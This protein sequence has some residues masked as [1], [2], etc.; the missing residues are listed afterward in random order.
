MLLLVVM[1][2]TSRLDIGTHRL[3]LTWGAW[4]DHLQKSQYNISDNKTPAWRAYNKVH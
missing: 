4:A 2:L 1:N 3:L